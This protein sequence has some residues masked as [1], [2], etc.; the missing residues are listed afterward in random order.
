MQCGADPASQT[1]P[2]PKQGP[3]Q[4]SNVIN[5]KSAGEKYFIEYTVVGPLRRWYGSVSQSVRAKGVW[6]RVQDLGSRVSDCGL[7]I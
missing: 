2:R 1:R 7:R 6:C 4:F 5:A 3:K